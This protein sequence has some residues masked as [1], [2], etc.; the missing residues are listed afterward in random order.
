MVY[1]NKDYAVQ[2]NTWSIKT[3]PRVGGKLNG[4]YQGSD[5]IVWSPLISNTSK[6]DNIN[7]RQCQQT[8]GDTTYN[9]INYDTYSGKFDNIMDVERYDSTSAHLPYYIPDNRQRAH[10][11]AANNYSAFR[12]FNVRD[13]YIKD[14]QKKYADIQQTKD[15]LYTQKYRK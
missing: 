13:L 6:N 9:R 11:D 10:Y 14:E 5:S 1:P 8:Y 12:K 15:R 4:W 7:A 2:A 3:A